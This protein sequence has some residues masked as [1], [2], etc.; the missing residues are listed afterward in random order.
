[1]TDRVT[2]IRSFR[3]GGVEASGC[4]KSPTET[5][6]MGTTFRVRVVRTIIQATD[7]MVVADDKDA[8]TK[9]ALREAQEHKQDEEWE[10]APAD[11]GQYW[12]DTIEEETPC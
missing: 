5:S 9:I 1:M 3:C 8:A 11:R 2:V 12:I 7:V 10:N 4:F 6:E